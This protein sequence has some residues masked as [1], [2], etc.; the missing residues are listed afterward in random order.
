MEEWITRF[1]SGKADASKDADW[2]AYL[3]AVDK[4]GLPKLIDDITK[5]YNK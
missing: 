1:I 4:A 2:K 5:K 3:A